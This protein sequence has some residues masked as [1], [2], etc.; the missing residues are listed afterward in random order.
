MLATALLFAWANAL[1]HA[2]PQFAL[3]TNNIQPIASSFRNYVWVNSALTG[4]QFPI[5]LVP[6]APPVA[7][8]RAQRIQEST[9]NIANYVPQV[10]D[11]IHLSIATSS[12]TDINATPM[13]LSASFQLT[14]SNE[15]QPWIWTLQIANAINSANDPIIRAGEC[16]GDR[17]AQGLPISSIAS[18]YRNFVWVGNGYQVENVDL[19]VRRFNTFTNVL[20]I[21][22]GSLD[23]NGLTPKVSDR[24]QL[25]IQG[26]DH[27]GGEQAPVDLSVE[28]ELNQASQLSA[29]IW[30]QLIADAINDLGNAD[31]RAGQCGNGIN[32]SECDASESVTSQPSATA[33][34]L[35]ARE[36]TEISSVQLSL[37]AN[38][39]PVADAGV[40]LII[41]ELAQFSLDGS[42]SKDADGQISSYQWQQIGGR[43]R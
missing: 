8:L 5:N 11:V 7:F 20:Q 3:A 32:L 26:I 13:P 39:A 14:Q 29:D 17:C 35:W 42:A 31:F 10:N 18:V 28:I 38:A 4:T 22:T 15:S 12:L 41:D 43:A 33:N 23:T 9:L 25:S 27:T 6:D 16:N 30:S 21:G 1:P 37:R 36:T 19:M 34:R 2:F 24:I 40:D